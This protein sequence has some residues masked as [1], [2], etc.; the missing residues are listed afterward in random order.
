MSVWDELVG[1]PMVVDQLRAAA[2]LERPTH[3]WLF[4]GPPG[5]GRSNAALAFA[6]ALQCEQ[7]DPSLRGCGECKA[8][9]SVLARTHPDVQITATEAVTIKI[10]EARALV[11]GAFDK[12]ATGRWR[13]LI[14]EDADRMLERST[15]V[16]LKAIEEPPPHT[17]WMLCAPSPADV[18]VTIRSRCRPVRLSVPPVADVARLLVE[19]DGADPQVAG[20][21]ARLA[22]SHVGIARR[23]AADDDARKRRQDIVAL[24]GRLHS[25]SDA[26]AAARSLVTLADEEAASSLAD[27][28]ATE[29]EQLLKT[30]GAPESGPLPPALRSQVKRLEEEQTRRAKRSKNDYYDRAL[31]DLLSFYRDVLVVQLARGESVGIINQE[32]EGTVRDIAEQGS[33]LDTLRRIDAINT[34]R[35]RLTKTNVAPQLAIEAMTLALL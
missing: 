9:R 23:L 32:I 25:I 26:M 27:R 19:R 20:V 2:A 34:V 14:V 15:N 30:L 29:R 3:A 28:D 18:L 5:S 16:L 10:E 21:A 7:A 6:A 22:Q 35:T 33:A 12:P 1:Q 4:T 8:C 13:I 17:I 31:T 24:P 11:S